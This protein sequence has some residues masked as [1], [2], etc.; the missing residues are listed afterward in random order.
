MPSTQFDKHHTAGQSHCI[1]GRLR[2]QATNVYLY[3]TGAHPVY[4]PTTSELIAIGYDKALCWAQRWRYT[5]CDFTLAD[6]RFRND[7]TTWLEQSIISLVY[8]PTCTRKIQNSAS[9][10][11]TPSPEVLAAQ[12]SRSSLLAHGEV[13][14]CSPG[15]DPFS[16]HRIG[17]GMP[18]RTLPVFTWTA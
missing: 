12:S 5:S 6:N 10:P 15:L 14:H 4:P 16:H 11:H 8:F 1:Q 2:H 17:V 9:P 3:G 18:S 13:L 7:I